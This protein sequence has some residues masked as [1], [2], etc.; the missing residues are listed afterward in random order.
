MS[1]KFRS[2]FL[3]SAVEKNL[4]GK[5]IY[6]VNKHAGMQVLED[7]QTCLTNSNLNTDMF[8]T[9][10]C[11]STMNQSDI[12]RKIDYFRDKNLPFAWW[13]G[14]EGEPLHF[15]TLLN[16]AGLQKTEEELAMTLD[17]SQAQLP[18]IPSHLFIQPANNPQA[19]TDMIEVLVRL[20]PTEGNAIQDFYAS[21]I[22][23]LCDRES[24]LQF[25]VGYV[26]QEP[27][28]T[29]S[30]YFDEMSAGIYDIIALPQHRGKGIG[31][32]MTVCGLKAA[33]ERGYSLSVLTAT[34][35]AKY[36]YEKLGF[37]ALK[38]MA[39][40]TQKKICS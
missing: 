32:A 1:E 15:K 31:T 35:D 16:E 8:N 5:F 10:I 23:Y 6:L 3:I 30:V 29:A 24:R 27:V 13:Q 12:K 37:R 7:N 33:Q 36:L 11:K 26:N 18:D 38:Q 34:N 39:V 20:I 25:F 28:G 14:F 22:P 4:R 9:V 17:L 19:L 2:D 40:Y 21:S